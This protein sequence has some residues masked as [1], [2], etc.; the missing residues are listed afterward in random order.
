L[1]THDDYLSKTR[2]HAGLVVKLQEGTI[3]SFK[4]KGC[5]AKCVMR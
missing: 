5:R 1:T 2:H 4:T 3:L